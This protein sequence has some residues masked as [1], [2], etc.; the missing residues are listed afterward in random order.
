MGVIVR[1]HARGRAPLK[2]CG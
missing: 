1:S 2:V